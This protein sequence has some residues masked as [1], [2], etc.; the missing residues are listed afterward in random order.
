MDKAYKAIARFIP[1]SPYKIRLLADVIRK[2][3]TLEALRWLDSYR[4]KRSIPL[5][6]VIESAL[7]NAKNLNPEFSDV[8]SFISELKV[9]QGPM[10]KYIK[11]GAQGRSS[12]LRRRY[13]HIYVEVEEKNK[14]NLSNKGN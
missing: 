6:K 11:P 14:S 5:K 4:T 10:R 2:K 3:N 7:A 1:F 8:N 13:C 12:V 9:D